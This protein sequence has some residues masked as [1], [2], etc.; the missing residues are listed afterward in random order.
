MDLPKPGA[1]VVR[2][3]QVDTLTRELVQGWLDSQEETPFKACL[4]LTAAPTQKVRTFLEPFLLQPGGAPKGLDVVSIRKLLEAGGGEE[5]VR[6]LCRS[7][8][9]LCVLQPALVILEHAALWFNDASEPLAQRNQQAQMRL[10]QQWARYAHAH[11]VVPVEADLPPWAAFADGLADVSNQGQFE[12]RPWWPTQWGL[13]SSLWNEP[14]QLGKIGAHH[15]LDSRGYETLSALAA[16][17][18][19]LR[20]EEPGQHA[21]H[22]QGNGELTSQD[23]SVLL[24]LGADTV[25][26]NREKVES[27]LG[28]GHIQ[29]QRHDKEKPAASTHFARD[30]HEVFTPG[31]LTLLAA[32][33]FSVNGLMLLQLARRWSVH[34]SITRLSL[35]RHMTAQTA[36]RLVNWG[37]AGAVFTATREA[38]Y[39]LKLWPSEP[40]E[41]SYREWLDGCF[42][43]KLP[44]LFSGDIQF[45]GHDTQVT[46][47]NDLHEEL[48]PLSV[49][50]ILASPVEEHIQLAELWNQTGQAGQTSRPWAQRLGLLQGWGSKS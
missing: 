29:L 2:A 17:C 44:V 5:G 12:F 30:L 6:A 45:I 23:A 18:H 48:E 14:A 10:L 34:C 20:F 47:L 40:A 46:L 26:L 19:Q 37:D 32:P 50:D 33:D 42:R 28:I 11:V 24:R 38:V 27:W 16:H 25:W 3:N 22:V 15:L 31:Q 41:S 4:W 43:E 8:N 13:Q 35:M 7:L 21:V 9:T 1:Y 39:L 36:M 49:E